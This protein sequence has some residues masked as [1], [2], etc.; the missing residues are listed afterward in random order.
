VVSERLIG[1]DME[2]AVVAQFRVISLHSPG[3]TEKTAKILSA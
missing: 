2:G 1:K 3:G